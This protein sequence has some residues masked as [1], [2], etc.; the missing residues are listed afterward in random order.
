MYHI[1][2]TVSHGKLDVLRAVEKVNYNK[3]THVLKKKILACEKYNCT[4]NSLLFHK[5]RL[6]DG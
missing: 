2:S 1:V 4:V 6:P 5:I 3:F